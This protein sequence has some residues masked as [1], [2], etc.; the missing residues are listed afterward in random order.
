M[1]LYQV[2]DSFLGSVSHS[3]IYSIWEQTK[4][5]TYKE[6]I[7]FFKQEYI[8]I[9]E[10]NTAKDKL[11][12]VKEGYLELD[13]IVLAKSKKDSD[14]FIL[15]RRKS[16]GGYIVNSVSIVLL[17]WTDGKIRVPIRIRIRKK[18]ES[19]GKSLLYLI[20]WYRNNINK[21]VEYITFDSAFSSKEVLTRINDYGWCFVTKVA[22]TR[23][24]NGK[25]VYRTHRG[26]Y[27]EKIGYINTKF[28]VK[29][30]RKEDN[31]YITN[32]INLNRHKIEEMYST[33]S[34]IE[35]VFRILKQT[36]HWDHCQLR[37]YND[38][39]RFYI[40]GCFEFLVLEYMRIKGFG[41]TIYKIR[42]QLLLGHVY[43]PLD[44]IERIL[45]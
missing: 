29:V 17:I 2:L 31:F 37:K 10:I 8:D 39:E 3:S 21:K 42:K 6:L 7:G 18:A 24:F 19:V 26:G 32:R 34:I 9:D 38:Y 16:A 1:L 15:R 45:A 5:C 14:D 22:K 11:F 28:K 4:T 41:T 33:R 43:A 44:E 12:N 35:E 36:C 25:Q 20:G 27:F 40:T 23:K 30:V 13:E